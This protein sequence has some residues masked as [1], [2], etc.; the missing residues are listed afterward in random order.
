MNEAPGAVN[1]TMFSK[2]FGERLRNTDPEDVIKNIFTDENVD[3][4]CRKEPIK[5]G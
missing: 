3:K 5:A 4:M 2:L 1:F